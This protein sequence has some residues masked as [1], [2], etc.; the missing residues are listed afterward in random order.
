MTGAMAWA[1]GALEERCDV[2][3]EFWNWRFSGLDESSTLVVG[4]KLSISGIAV[5][6][7]EASS[8]LMDLVRRPVDDLLSVAL[9]SEVLFDY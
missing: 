9:A 7:K 3:A 8:V 4:A 6:P 2:V 5:E 1:L